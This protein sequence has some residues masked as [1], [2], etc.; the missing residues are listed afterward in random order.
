MGG[1]FNPCH[2]GHISMANIACEEFS[3][4]QTLIVPTGDPP[5]KASG[6]AS[7]EHRFA[8]CELAAR[9]YPKLVVSRLEIERPGK[10]YTVDT[11]RRFTPLQTLRCILSWV[12][13]RFEKFQH[14][15]SLNRCFR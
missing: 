1:T 2:L 8:M 4:D 14:G 6:L 5:H 10:T 3:L 13:I 9:S 7:P 12:R 15:K 11:L